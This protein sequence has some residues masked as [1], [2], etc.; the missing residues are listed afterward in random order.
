MRIQSNSVA[1]LDAQPDGQVSLFAVLV[2]LV[3]IRNILEAI[4]KLLLTSFVY[5]LPRTER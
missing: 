5:C 4:G 3:S 2:V 1:A